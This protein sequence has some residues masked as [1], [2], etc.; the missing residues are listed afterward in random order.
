MLTGPVHSTAR[1]EEH[2][3]A[4]RRA[5]DWLG[6]TQGRAAAYAKLITQF[7]KGSSRTEEQVLAYNESCEI[8]DLFELW[9]R[10]ADEF[11][12]LRERL[13][14][15][16]R[17]GPTLR[18]GEKPSASGNRPRND[19]FV[20]LLGGTLLTAKVSV[21]A[22]DGVC[23]RGFRGQ[24]VADLTLSS[25][26]TCIDVEC[27]RPQTASSV[28]PRMR[29]ARGQLEDPARERRPGVVAIDCSVMARPSGTL[30]EYE[31]GPKGEVR[32]SERLQAFTS[33]LNPHLTPQVLGV[34]LF[35]RVAGMARVGQSPILGPAGKPVCEFRPETIKSWLFVSNAQASGPDVLREIC[36]RVQ[37]QRHEGDSDV[38]SL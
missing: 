16:C 29:E 2:V 24:C 30:L 35:A 32:V 21:V 10:H 8:V 5:C 9:S 37:L 4:I 6:I 22:V 25:A 33:A 15:V 7:F 27:K 31:S 17:K 1:H 11:P 23:R 28:I 19:A 34:I 38:R 18:E 12:G 13:R 36:I 3:E 20:Y 26:S 14:D